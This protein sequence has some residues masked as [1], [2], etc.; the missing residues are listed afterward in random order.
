MDRSIS[1]LITNCLA[2]MILI[3][4][5]SLTHTFELY[6]WLQYYSLEDLKREFGN[7]GFCIEEYYSDVAGAPYTSNSNEIA[8]VAR[9][10]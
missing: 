3:G 9:K 1:L 7:N 4:N 2:A 6:K 10:V 8:I 5:F